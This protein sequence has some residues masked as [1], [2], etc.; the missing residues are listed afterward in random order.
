MRLNNS[1]DTTSQV[2]HT[3]TEQTH[4]GLDLVEL[5]IKQSIAE[6]LVEKGLAPESTDMM[7]T[8][9]DAMVVAAISKGATNAVEA[10]IYA[11][12]PNENFIPSPG[13]LQH[14][15]FGDMSQIWRRVDSWVR[16]YLGIV[17]P[18]DSCN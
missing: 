18:S 10:R 6:H 14:V 1:A 15:Y 2:E 9:Y 3:I 7:Q 5:M 13:L 4:D 16:I 11:E 8:T 12:N 17:F